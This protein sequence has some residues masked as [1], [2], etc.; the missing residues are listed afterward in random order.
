LSKGDM[1]LF[2]AIFAPFAGLTGVDFGGEYN[3]N[4]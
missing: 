2:P 1:S 4:Q 3:A